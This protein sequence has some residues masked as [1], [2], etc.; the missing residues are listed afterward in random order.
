MKRGMLSGQGVH[1]E[2][3]RLQGGK[4]GIFGLGHSWGFT[5][6]DD[7]KSFCWL[8]QRGEKVVSKLNQ[9]RRKEKRSTKSLF[10]DMDHSF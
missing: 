3:E 8:F 5:W 1:M 6:E 4:K 7:R 2:N 10:R 9:C